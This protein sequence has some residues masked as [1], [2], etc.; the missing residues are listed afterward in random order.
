[1]DYEA[2]EEKTLEGFGTGAV[3]FA[4]LEAVSAMGGSYS[5]VAAALG[6]IGWVFLVGLSILGI[7]TGLGKGKAS[8]P[9]PA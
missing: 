1:M 5:A 2:F 3:S 8:A 4:V 9:K 7:V 6:P